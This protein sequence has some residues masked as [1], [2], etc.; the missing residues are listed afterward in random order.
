MIP[1]P[2]P[3]RRSARPVAGVCPDPTGFDEWR[4]RARESERRGDTGAALHQYDR[5]L[6]ALPEPESDT[7]AADILRS[8]GSVYRERGELDRAE[9]RYKES[10]ALAE[11]LGYLD[12]TA[13]AGNWL[14]VIAMG[15]GHLAEAEALFTRACRTAGRVRNERLAGAIEQNLGILANIRGD[16]DAAV[17]HY[18]TALR[19]FR[20]AGDEW[21]LGLVL[22]NLGLLHSDLTQFAEAAAAFDEA[23]DLAMRTGNTMLENSVEVNRAEMC[24]GRQDWEA[25]S[26][27]CARARTLA[28]LR[29]DRQREA[30][31]LKFQGVIARE[32]NK[33]EDAAWLLGEAES[34]AASCDDRLLMAEVARESGELYVR[35]GRP[36]DARISFSRALDLFQALGAR[37]DHADTEARLARL[38]TD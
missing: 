19:Q 36:E 5:A 21:M 37:L 1:S 29:N 27:A 17:I 24:I 16:L 3:G 13:N 10:Y 34:L 35:F 18:R 14:G 31:A 6:A 28:Q 2:N 38:L 9:R 22:N 12:G 23:H 25:A 20:S 4:L 7:R 15:R 32:Q 8:M 11:G 33:L 26:A 30:E